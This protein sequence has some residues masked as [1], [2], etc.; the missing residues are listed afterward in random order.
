MLKARS[1]GLHFVLSLAALTACGGGGG[2]SGG[3]GGGTTTSSTTTASGGSTTSS[4]T[5]SSTTTSST[6]SGTSTDCSGIYGDETTCPG[7]DYGVPIMDVPG[8]SVTASIVDETGA[9]VAGQPIYICGTNLCSPPGTTQSN[10]AASINTSLGMTK[11]AFKFGDA[12]E[13]AEISIPLTQA[14]NDFTALGTGKLATGK[15]SDKP[16]AVLMPG[17]QA[18]SGDVTVSLPADASVIIDPLIYDTCDKQLLR[19][20][21]IPLANL[22]P[23]LDPV[24]IGGAPAGFAAY[25]GLAPA[26]TTV[27]PAAK[28]T[29]A[30]PHKTATPNDFGWAP[31]AA[32]EFWIT[33][34]SSSGVYA[35][36]AGWA[37]A[38]DGTVSAD[39]TTVS[40]VDGGGFAVLENFAIRLKGP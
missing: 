32:V 2:G 5:T 37:K 19:T 21:N 29:V 17:T 8:G 3:G 31:N 27:C 28:V 6:T 34:V 1:L 36:Y 22:G 12:V 25:Y 15:L 14:T 10:G 30:L 11:P 7:G 16:G 38:S 24:M 23:V 20:V 39:G 33:T 35:P 9:P 18:T 26:M 40:T 4:T 13:Y